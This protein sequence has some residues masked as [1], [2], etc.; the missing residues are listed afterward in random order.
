LGLE[1]KYSIMIMNTTI[2]N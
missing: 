2:R 1:A